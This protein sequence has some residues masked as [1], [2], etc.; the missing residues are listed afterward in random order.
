MKSDVYV[1]PSWEKAGQ[2]Q[3]QLS[4][5]FSRARRIDCVCCHVTLADSLA[6]DKKTFEGHRR[7]SNGVIHVLSGWRLYGGVYEDADNKWHLVVRFCGIPIHKLLKLGSLMVL[8]TLFHLK[9]RNW[10]QTLQDAHP[11]DPAIVEEWSH[12]MKLRD[13]ADLSTLF[14]HNLDDLKVWWCLILSALSTHSWRTLRNH[15][16]PFARLALI[17]KGR[18]L[19]W[20]RCVRKVSKVIQSRR[21]WCV[22]RRTL[23]LSQIMLIMWITGLPYS[24]PS[25]F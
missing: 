17:A 18:E 12:V 20:Q 21:S 2:A 11:A 23:L 25:R 5:M 13:C 9:P 7:L 6:T 8:Q 24:L 19:S 14:A 15:R 16:G 4:I 1:C 10:R 3:S 22:V